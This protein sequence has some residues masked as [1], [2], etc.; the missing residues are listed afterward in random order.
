M[1]QMDAST[2]LS[3]LSLKIRFPSIPVKKTS[4]GQSDDVMSEITGIIRSALR[5]ADLL[6]HYGSKEFVAL[7]LRTDADAAVAVAARVA[8]RFAT[9]KSNE[10]VAVDTQISI[11]IATAPVDGSNLDALLDSARSREHSA[12]D[13]PSSPP[14]G[15]LTMANTNREFLIRTGRILDALKL[16]REQLVSRDPEICVEYAELLHRAGEL[17]EAERAAASLEVEDSRL[18]ESLRARCDRCESSL[19][20]RVRA[21]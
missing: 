16:C 18:S 17:E 8:G 4:H 2:Y 12:G 20:A 1:T 15:T 9:A 7:L 5:G 11:G 14:I 10:Q 19:S 21:L 13:Y 6:F 3:I